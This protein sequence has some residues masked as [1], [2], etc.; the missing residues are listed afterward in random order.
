MNE[1]SPV[2]SFFRP[3]LRSVRA[4]CVQT[5]STNNNTPMQATAAAPPTASSVDHPMPSARRDSIDHPSPTP[6]PQHHQHHQQNSYSGHYSHPYPPTLPGT[7]S[8]NSNAVHA[9]NGV[10]PSPPDSSYATVSATGTTGSQ[11]STKPYYQHQPPPSTYVGPASQQ[12][13]REYGS[14]PTTPHQGDHQPAASEVYHESTAA[15][16]GHGLSS[17]SNNSN[18]IPAPG[19]APSPVAPSSQQPSGHISSVVASSTSPSAS[20]LSSST[21]ALHATP[22]TPSPPTPSPPEPFQGRPLPPIEPSHPLHSYMSNSRRGSIT[23]P[24]YHASAGPNSG[25]TLVDSRRPSL[26]ETSPSHYAGPSSPEHRHYP[27]SVSSPVEPPHY[28][29]HAP[30]FRQSDLAASRRESLPSIHSSAGPLGQLLAQEPQRRHSIAHSDPLGG[31]GVPGPHGHHHPG[32]KRKTSGTPLSQVHTSSALDYP[33]AKRRDSIPDTALHHPYHQ[34]RQP[35]SAPSSPPRRGSIA[36]HGPVPTLSLQ[37]AAEIKPHGM[38]H[39]MS[40]SGQPVDHGRPLF[41]PHQPRRPSL[42]SDAGMSLSRRSSLAEVHHHAMHQSQQDYD[43]RMNIDMERMHLSNGAEGPHQ[44]PPM[45]G[46]PPS[47][48]THLYPGYHP[49]YPQPEPAPQ[50][51]ETP[52]SRSP[53]LRISHKLAERKRRKEMKELFDELRDSLPVDRSLK[54]SKW[55]ILSKA[56]DYISNMKAAQEDL[57]KEVE[58]LRE[59][60]QRLKADRE[61]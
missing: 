48:G 8:S 18:S 38:P 29:S 40:G 36:H 1:T 11:G 28:V 35:Y 30:Q 45:Q 16:P 34:S 19:N 5:S 56:V 32:L 9:P 52:Y 43:H 26:M 7:L 23:D 10:H 53:E 55:E 6:S 41:P 51:P 25:H 33:P 22:S 61:K 17:N 24:E 46:H 12:P 15:H 54:T 58:M 37:P 3:S 60:V 20:S 4:T 59:E 42:L 47:Q 13:R 2:V 14:S 49:G 44:P 39:T 21:S 57:T 31:P 27:A 50:K